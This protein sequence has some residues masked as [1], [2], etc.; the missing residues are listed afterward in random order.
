MPTQR[1]TILLVVACVIAFVLQISI[2]PAISLFGA[3]P[4]FLLA[5]A[6]ALAIATP[7]QAGCILPFVMGLAYDL[8]GTGPVGGMALILCVC[9]VLA[10]RA[11]MV[12]N[13]D[14][15][16]MPLVLFV[17]CAL[18][19]EFAYGLLLIS[20]GLSAS[21]GDALLVRALPCAL[22]DCAVGLIAYPACMKLFGN[23]A[24]NTRNMQAPK[25]R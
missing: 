20:C 11:F 24:P 2:A 12:L 25:I 4:N 10:S 15:V 16:F 22:Y 21:L 17:I 5:L 14:T 8:T 3:Q 13:N 6:L 1:N 9:C 19:C 18:V 23:Q 7:A